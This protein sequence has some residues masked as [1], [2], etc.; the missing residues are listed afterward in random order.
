MSK[1]SPFIL[2]LAA[3]D[4][5]EQASA[6]AARRHPRVEYRELTGSGQAVLFDFGAATRSH[7]GKAC[8]RMAG[9]YWATA[10]GSFFAHGAS[11]SI[12]ATGEDVGLP[13]A[14]VN[15]LHRRSARPAL[16]IIFHGS[17]LASKKLKLVMRLLHSRDDVRFLCL[18]SS[19][20]RQLV[21]RAGGCPE[22]V[23]VVGY[24]VDTDFFHPDALPDSAIRTR[25]IASAGTAGRDYRTLLSAVRELDADVEIAADSAWFPSAIDIA[26]ERLPPRVSVRSFGDYVNLRRLYTEAAIV[27]VPLYDSPRATGYA[28]IIE[29]MAM[30]KPVVATATQG[31]SDMII[32]GETGFYVSPGAADELRQTLKYL[33][34]NPEVGSSVG[35]RAREYV[36]AN[37]SVER[38]VA[39]IL[40]VADG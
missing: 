22:R 30:G 23:A 1:A 9:P 29:A 19:I 6:A 25:L 12:I 20:A 35:Q 33:L 28:V 15:A 8:A 24:G 32:D 14:L 7:L 26:D 4:N 36:L 11:S 40:E 5:D 27:V 38:Y 39:R 34:E 2:A 16:S 37:A 17:Y 31:R 3:Y 13:M 21:D 10:L 18:S